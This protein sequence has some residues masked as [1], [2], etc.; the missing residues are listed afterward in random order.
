M[1]RSKIHS[2][3][4]T[5]SDAHVKWLEYTGLV[6]FVCWID[7]FVELTSTGTASVNN[8]VSRARESRGGHFVEGSCIIK[9]LVK[10]TPQSH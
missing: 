7:P 3:A 1:Q 6:N 8:A 5:F 10:I 9:L 4:F 2:P